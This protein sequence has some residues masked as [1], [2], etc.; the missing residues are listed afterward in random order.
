[1]QRIAWLRRTKGWGV[2]QMVFLDESAA[3]ERT[4]NK[5]DG[6]ALVGS[7]TTVSSSFYQSQQ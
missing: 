7:N 2:E 4:V 3:C 5:A 6:W 1:M